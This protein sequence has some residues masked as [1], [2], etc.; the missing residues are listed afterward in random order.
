MPIENERKY[1]LPLN[2]DPRALSA[3][4]SCEIKQAYLDD[5]PRL[6]QTGDARFFTYKRLIPQ[7]GELVEIETEISNED[8]A[9]LW[10]QCITVLSKT[11]YEKTDV[12]GDWVVDFLRDK[13]DRLYFVLAEVELPRGV[14]A[15][16]AIPDELAPHIVHAVDAAD[17]RFTNKKLSDV[18]VAALLYDEIAT[19]R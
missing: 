18:A 8:F 19:S 10:S 2:F 5:G 7:T 1:V 4:R 16:S 12:S 9:L 6:R 15:P 11:R 17:V 13:S 3:W 14:A